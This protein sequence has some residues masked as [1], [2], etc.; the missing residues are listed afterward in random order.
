MDIMSSALN[1][2]KTNINC[3]SKQ[4][5]SLYDLFHSKIDKDLNRA[6]I[7]RNLSMETKL[8]PCFLPINIKEPDDRVFSLIF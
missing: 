6:Q 7:R 5:C 3:L 4:D 2:T 8:H 1:D